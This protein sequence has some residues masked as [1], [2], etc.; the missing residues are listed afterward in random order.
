MGGNELSSTRLPDELKKPAQL[1]SVEAR[2]LAHDPPLPSVPHHFRS[3]LEVEVRWCTNGGG[4]LGGLDGCRT[5][6][7]G[8]CGALL[9]DSRRSTVGGVGTQA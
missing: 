4:H 3:G 5:P 8:W 6:R 7:S 2:V 9:S 1:G